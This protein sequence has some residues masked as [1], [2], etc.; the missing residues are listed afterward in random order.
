MKNN[1]VDLVKNSEHS[2]KSLKSLKSLRRGSS[3]VI[4]PIKFTKIQG[5]RRSSSFEKLFRKK[6]NLSRTNLLILIS[7]EITRYNRTCKVSYNSVSP[8]KIAK[9]SEK[10][11]I[12][13]ENPDI[14]NFN[15]KNF[16]EN[17]QIDIDKVRKSIKNQSLKIYNEIKMKKK[18]ISQRK[19][20]LQISDFSTKPSNS[21]LTADLYKSIPQIEAKFYENFKKISMMDKGFINRDKVESA[22]IKLQIQALKYKKYNSSQLDYLYDDNKFD[23]EWIDTLQLRGV[24]IKKNSESK[25]CEKNFK[26]MALSSKNLAFKNLS[27]TSNMKSKTITKNLSSTVK[28]N[29]AHSTNSSLT[30]HSNLKSKNKK[31]NF[32]HRATMLESSVKGNMKTDEISDN[33]QYTRSNP[34]SSKNN[35]HLDIDSNILNS[36]NEITNSKLKLS[37][38]SSYLKKHTYN[39]SVIQLKRMADSPKYSMGSTR[40]NRYMSNQLAEKIPIIDDNDTFESKTSENDSNNNSIITLSDNPNY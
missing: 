10:I 36:R 2:K 3:P 4:S 16:Y 13:I 8:S 26:M 22:F 9:E 7:E 14:P 27:P 21:N 11:S 19:L 37:N 34:G 39:G 18:L 28:N 32:K 31:V 38:K 23:D 40:T 15:R 20:K 5:I 6:A 12:V 30:L 1:E 24:N 25:F 35:I 17:P 29:F 33:T